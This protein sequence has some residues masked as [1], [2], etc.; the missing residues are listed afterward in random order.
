MFKKFHSL[1]AWAILL[2]SSVPALSWDPQ[3]KTDSFRL[4]TNGPGTIVGAHRF[5]L[6][7]NKKTLMEL[8]WD[9]RLGYA[10]LKNANPYIDPWRLL[11]GRRVLLPYATIFPVDA[12]PG[13]TINLAELLLYYLWEE[14][15]TWHVRTYPVGIGSEGTETPAGEF[16][17]LSKKENPIWTVPQSVR[18]EKP[19]LPDMVHPGSTNPLGKFWMGFSSNGYGI[20]GTNIPLGIGRRIS[21]GCLRLY[22]KD[23]QDLFSRVPVGTPVKI[24]NSPV[25]AGQADGILFIEV[26]RTF[27]ED[28]DQLKR[29]FVRQA[30]ALNWN[31]TLDWESIE[32]ALSENRGIPFA[33]SRAGY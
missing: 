5:H 10:N 12:S 13:I 30:R 32:R 21:H 11:N 2:L 14:D 17:I 25:K 26:H 16:S 19:D 20:H 9:N 1:A 28:A 23:I 7:K 18:A 27:S 24:I 29:D 33:V 31:G 4:E 6:I 22:P 3:E 15:G 8:A